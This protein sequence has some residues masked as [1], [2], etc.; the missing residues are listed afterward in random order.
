MGRVAV[1]GN[2]RPAPQN[3]ETKFV[4]VLQN[5]LEEIL[6]PAHW[7]CLGPCG[8]VH[9]GVLHHPPPS[10]QCSSGSVPAD[11]IAAD[12]ILGENILLNPSLPHVEHRL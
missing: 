7:E 5:L 1:F 4:F 6:L 2:E 11:H 9:H 3:F 12:A 10:S 8:S